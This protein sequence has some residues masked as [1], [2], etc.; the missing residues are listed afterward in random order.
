MIKKLKE[1]VDLIRD[2]NGQCLM[3]SQTLG[4]LKQLLKELE[5]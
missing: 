1:L 2:F 5:E 4:S 3:L